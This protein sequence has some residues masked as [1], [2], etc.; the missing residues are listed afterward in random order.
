M[1]NR[2]SDETAQGHVVYKQIVADIKCTVTKHSHTIF[3]VIIYCCNRKDLK[4][5]KFTPEYSDQSFIMKSWK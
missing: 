5:N 3:C 1:N 4:T 2:H